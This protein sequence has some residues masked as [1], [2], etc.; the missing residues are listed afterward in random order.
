MSAHVSP[1]RSF[2]LE[3]LDG[4]TADLVRRVQ[5][6]GGPVVLT[7]DGV[8]LAVLLSPGTFEALEAEV[9]RRKLQRAVDD[10]EQQVSAGD[11]VP[12]EEVVAEL[13]RWISDAA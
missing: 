12:H 4:P 2:T 1:A 5:A 11:T 10:A 3:D 9:D 13:D 6:E 8:P 7:R